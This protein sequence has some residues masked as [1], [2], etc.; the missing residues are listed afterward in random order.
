[1]AYETLDDF[2]KQG[3]K[4]TAI[5]PALQQ[6][7]NAAQQTASAADPTQGI[8]QNIGFA[9]TAPGQFSAGLGG[10][11]DA[12]DSIVRAIQDRAQKRSKDFVGS[13]QKESKYMQPVRESV[14]ARQAARNQGQIADVQLGNL[15]IE[16]Q[17]RLDKKRIDLYK[18]Q[19]RDSILAGI[20]GVIGTVGGA[21]IGG[22]IGGPAGAVAGAAAGGK[23]GG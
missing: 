13:L 23:A 7:V 10:P 2:K 5:D 14:A 17:H 19:Q 22:A 20:L 6:M 18:Q 3:P 21:I 16:Q 4:K 15:K 11:V 1:M 12:S 9:K 8:E